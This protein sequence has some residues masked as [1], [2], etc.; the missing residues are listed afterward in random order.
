MKQNVWD[1]TACSSEKILF[2]K[3]LVEGELEID[4]VSVKSLISM[5]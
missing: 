1:W 4:T 3:C 2:T 5:L